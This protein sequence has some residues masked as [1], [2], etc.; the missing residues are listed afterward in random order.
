MTKSLKMLTTES[1]SLMANMENK[2]SSRMKKMKLIL[3]TV[4]FTMIVVTC[5]H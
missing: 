1:V 5:R 4:L 3:L 2:A